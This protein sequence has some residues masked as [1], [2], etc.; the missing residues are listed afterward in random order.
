MVQLVSSRPRI[1]LDVCRV[2]DVVWFDP[3]ETA[4][5]PEA[6]AKPV[7]TFPLREQEL[8][9]GQRW[10]RERERVGSS[11]ASLSWDGVS[12]AGEQP[13]AAWK[14][15]PAIL[16]FPVESESTAPSRQP[17]L[18]WTIALAVFGVSVAAFGSLKESVHEFG[19][20]PAAPWRH[21]GLTWITS[22][23]LHGGVMHLVGNLYFLLIFGDNVEDYV[24]RWRYALL[25]LASTLTGDLVHLVA[26]P[27][28]TVPCIGASGGISGIIVFYAL[29]FPR[30]RLGF[31][32]RFFWVHLPAWG[33]L[34]LWLG[35]QLLTLGNQLAGKSQIGATAHLGGAFAGLLLWLS[36]RWLEHKD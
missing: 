20:V 36:W 11:G 13:D 12:A 27:G 18:T 28:S 26:S 35:L 23:F 24:G 19:F 14:T 2:C 22:F 10:D 30:A 4:A 33:A 8:D 21:A 25:L 9:I 29:Q 1:A 31:L 6:P 34:L 5:L 16:G 7:P 15:I 3:H 32:L 17:W